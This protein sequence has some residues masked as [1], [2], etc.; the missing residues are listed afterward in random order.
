MATDR[1]DATVVRLIKECE[2]Y[3]YK[4]IANVVKH[5]S[6]SLL[7]RKQMILKDYKKLGSDPDNP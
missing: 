7:K 2:A 6:Q 5:E 4:Q 3:M 1:Y